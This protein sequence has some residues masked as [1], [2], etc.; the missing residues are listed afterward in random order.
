[1]RELFGSLKTMDDCT[2]Q[3]EEEATF[4]VGKMHILEGQFLKLAEIF[5]NERVADLRDHEV[6]KQRD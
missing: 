2:D 3:E 4:L 1:M 6:F 5:F